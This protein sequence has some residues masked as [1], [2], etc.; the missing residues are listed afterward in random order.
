MTR[1]LP[2]PAPA[3]TR[4]GP[5]A[6]AAAAAC[7]SLSSA[8]D[9]VFGCEVYVA[10]AS[11]KHSAAQGFDEDLHDVEPRARS[12]VFLRIDL[13][14]RGQSLFYG[15]AFARVELEVS[16]PPFGWLQPERLARHPDGV[17]RA[18]HLR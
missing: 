17:E 9:I 10:E 14:Q 16:V 7:G 11:R 13:W 12:V 1:V 2:L 18:V 4:R 3:K 8:S 6:C 15:V 5:F